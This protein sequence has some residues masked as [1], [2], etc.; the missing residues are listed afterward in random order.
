M[1]SLV[2]FTLNAFA[3]LAV[4]DLSMLTRTLRTTQNIDDNKVNTDRE[5]QIKF[6]SEQLNMIFTRGHLDGIKAVF[7]AMESPVGAVFFTYIEKIEHSLRAT[8]TE[9][10]YVIIESY[11]HD[12]LS[13]LVSKIIIQQNYFMRLF[14]LLRIIQ[15]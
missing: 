14:V 11:I 4:S 1:S 12:S 15:N 10:D 8:L 2:N 13:L 7:H 5:N 6:I 9:N 3:F